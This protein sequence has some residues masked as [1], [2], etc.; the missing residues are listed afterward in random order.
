MPLS[1]LNQFQRFRET[2]CLLSQGSSTMKLDARGSPKLTRYQD[3]VILSHP[4]EN[5]KMSRFAH[6]YAC[7]TWVMETL[8]RSSKHI[9][10]WETQRVFRCCNTDYTIQLPI[11]KS[12]S[13]YFSLFHD[14]KWHLPCTV[15]FECT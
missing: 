10:V 12:M 6:Y 8:L 4:H 15:C 5:I 3:T 11:A 13:Q 7:I 1:L 14:R 9:T 2:C